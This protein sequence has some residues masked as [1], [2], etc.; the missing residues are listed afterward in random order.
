MAVRESTYG[1][2]IT[3]PT[4]EAVGGVI[5]SPSELPVVL[6]RYPRYEGLKKY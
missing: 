6:G 2:Q 3:I 5:L 1:L 4:T